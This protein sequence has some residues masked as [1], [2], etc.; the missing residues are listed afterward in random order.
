MM[1]LKLICLLVILLLFGC[2][3]NE[4]SSIDNDSDLIDFNKTDL[5]SEVTPI[6]INDDFNYSDPAEVVSP[7]EEESIVDVPVE[8]LK[9]DLHFDIG[10]NDVNVLLIGE[11][12][13]SSNL[14]EIYF[15]GNPVNIKYIK[16][17]G[18]N[19]DF[20]SGEK[21]YYYQKV[22]PN[23]SFSNASIEILFNYKPS[24]YSG[25]Y[26]ISRV[27]TVS[28]YHTWI[29]PFGQTFNFDYNTTYENFYSTDLSEDQENF[30]GVITDHNL[31]ERDEFYILEEQKEFE[32]E[33]DYLKIK[34]YKKNTEDFLNIYYDGE[35]VLFLLPE[36][37]SKGGE[38]VNNSLLMMFQVGGTQEDYRTFSHEYTHFL[39]NDDDFPL[40]IQEGMASYVSEKIVYR[41]SVARGTNL[42]ITTWDSIEPDLDTTLALYAKS[43]NV[44]HYFESK[45]GLDKTKELI[46]KLIDLPDTDV[47]SEEYKSKVE[48]IFQET[49]EQEYTLNQFTEKDY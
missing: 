32:K 16:V 33:L 1:K 10:F 40:W 12:Y 25:N 30:T 26:C 17:N 23:Q 13:S 47:Y 41:S 5:I 36:G 24:G 44:F 29:P 21:W 4:N 37:S 46:K 20:E 14:E 3:T 34:K 39:L 6:K 35:L 31:I 11:N 28:I 19:I 49:S 38:Y 43:S 7:V 48:K 22:I 15:P 27:C 2:T 42:D 18:E 45:F 9:T 8:K